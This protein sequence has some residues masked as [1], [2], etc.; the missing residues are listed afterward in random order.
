MLRTLET[1]TAWMSWAIRLIPTG[2][3]LHSLS[4]P[5]TFSFAECKYI[6]RNH[7][8][9]QLCIVSQTPHE[10]CDSSLL[11]SMLFVFFVCI[12]ALRISKRADLQTQW[13]LVQ[14]FRKK[15]FRR[16]HVVCIVP[17]CMYAIQ[18]N[19]ELSEQDW[20]STKTVSGQARLPY[21]P[22][23]RSTV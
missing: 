21:E 17:F 5:L 15:R 6:N 4:L 9:I 14:R 7:V 18:N 22:E 1:K 19:L 3:Y 23:P 2:K 11:S 16:K 12:F 20:L 10:S 13:R 8:I